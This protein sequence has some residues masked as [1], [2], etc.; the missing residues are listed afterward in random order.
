MSSPL[1]DIKVEQKGGA[2]IVRCYGRIVAG[3]G[4]DLSIRVRELIPS[5]QRIV[6]DLD[7]V[8]FLDS[9]G[10]GVLVRLNV[11]AR[12]AGVTLELANPSRQ[13]Q[14]L[15]TMTNTMSLFGA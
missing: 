8:T 2:A 14:Q 15:L 5:C 1:L 4:I 9:M 3:S 13:V 6:I 11:S 10:L 12:Q 7:K